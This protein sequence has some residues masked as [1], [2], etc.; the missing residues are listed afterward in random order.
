VPIGG[1]KRFARLCASS[2][3]SDSFMTTVLWRRQYNIAAGILN[4]LRD[5]HWLPLVEGEVS[6]T[7]AMNPMAGFVPIN[8]N[9]CLATC[10]EGVAI[11]TPKESIAHL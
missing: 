10:P 8:R 1:Q 3:F 7:C 2:G 9:G 4:D 5:L 11:T 6:D